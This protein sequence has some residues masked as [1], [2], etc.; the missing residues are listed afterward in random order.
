MITINSSLL[1]KDGT[2]D[3]KLLLGVLNK[4]DEVLKARLMPL[5]KLYNREHSI[6]FRL[7]L[8]GLPNNKLVHDF[9]RYIATMASGYLVG[10]P[11]QYAP[12]EEQEEAY[13]ALD[14]ALEAAKT[15][16]VDSELAVDASVYGKAVEL[17]YADGNAKPKTSE[18]N[19]LF[20]F[21]VY[22]DTVEHKPLFGVMIAIKT[23][24][25]LKE[26]G[27][28]VTVYTSTQTIEYDTSSVSNPIAVPTERS[29]KP[30]Y[31]GSVPMIEYW[32]N[33]DEIGDFEPVAS[34]INA[35]DELQSDRINDKQQF[36]DAIMVLKGVGNLGVDDTEEIDPDDPEAVADAEIKENMSPSERLRQT[37]TMFLPG[38]GADAGYITK[39]DS[40]GGNELLRKSVADDIHKFSFVPNL[41]DEKFAGISSGVAMRFKLLGLEQIV[42]VKERWFREALRTRLRL[43]ANFL[44]VKGAAAID[45]DKVQIT[46]SRSLPVNELEIAQTVQAYQD[47]VPDELLL[48]QV[49]F[50]EDADKALEML[51]KEQADKTKAS[52]MMFATQPFKQ[53]KEEEQ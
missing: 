14:D 8:S 24:V 31:F 15:D 1:R 48:G 30:H 34:L 5:Y 19:P 29:R 28:R 21:V 49:P 45:V 53:D 51:Q 12:P 39:P 9:P 25:T 47:I 2:P 42:S 16:C 6:V 4:H 18:I 27:K 23:D 10:K 7:R 3:E 32:N 26:I 38:D 35:Y 17:C 20:G 40:E 36:T 46:F 37:R 11:V 44:S 50:V 22:D 41:T 13:K 43:F 52:A 33:A